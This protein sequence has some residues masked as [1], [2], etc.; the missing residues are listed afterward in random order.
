[1]NAKPADSIRLLKA[2]QSLKIENFGEWLQEVK[3]TYQWNPEH[4]KLIREYLERILSGEIDRLMI[5]APPRHGKSEQVTIH[6]PAFVLEHNPGFRWI[7]GAYATGL[8]ARFSRR[9]RGIAAQ[10]IP[11]NP[12]RQTAAD[13]ETL[14]GGGLRAVGVGS[15]VTGHGANGII[16]DDPVKSR[17]EAESKAYRDACHEW[18]VDDLSTRLEPKGFIVMQMTRWHEDDLAGRILASEEGKEWTV[19]RLPAV[20]EDNGTEDPIGREPNEALWPERYN[21]AALMRIKKRLMSSFY[22]LFQ[23][24][25]TSAEGGIIKRHWIGRYTEYD[26]EV[27]MTVQ[28]WDCA[29][30]GN[31]GADFSVCTTWA[32]TRLKIYLVAEWRDQVDYPDLKKAAIAQFNLHKPT[33]VLVEDKGNGTALIQELQQHTIVPTVA[34]EP[35]ADKVV[36][37]STQSISYEAGM[38][39]HPDPA[40]NSWVLDFEAELT[41]IPNAANDDRG[42]SVSQAIAYITQTGNA[43]VFHS[44]GSALQSDSVPGDDTG[45]IDTE[46]GFGRITS[47]TDTGGF[48]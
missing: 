20:S 3:P 16:I 5:F 40:Y 48:I 7:I 22:A 28:S 33:V 10:R 1:L 39:L 15:G 12:K 6:W 44:P 29:N 14:A 34:V 18:Y 26:S 35:V 47:G 46:A 24:S 17:K 42:D 45:E 27:I 21:F 13:W 36:R 9:T 37:L 38:V 32:I 4:L 8:S 23:G 41:T 2:R 25:P 19:L 30:K 43:F 31:V 11:M